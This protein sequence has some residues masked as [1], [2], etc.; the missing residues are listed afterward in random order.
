M[1]VRGYAYHLCGVDMHSI[2]LPF[3]VRQVWVWPKLIFDEAGFV[4][5]GLPL[6]CPNISDE[7]RR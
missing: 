7:L 1:V 6:P 4:F 5:A 2:K 3:V